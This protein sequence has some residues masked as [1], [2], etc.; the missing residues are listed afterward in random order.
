MGFIEVHLW[1]R[2]GF[3]HVIIGKKEFSDLNVLCLKRPFEFIVLHRRRQTQ[4]AA[5]DVS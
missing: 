3:I 4:T 2:E 5:Q 1:C